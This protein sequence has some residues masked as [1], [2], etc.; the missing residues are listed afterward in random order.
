MKKIKV[1]LESLIFNIMLPESQT[2]LDELNEEI[3]NKNES[4]DI[5]EAKK[6]VEFFIEELNQILKLIE[7]N[8]LSNKDA[9]VMYKKLRL[10]L[11][12]HKH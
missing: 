7:E 10:M 3:T 2:F 1:E 8:K 4:K 12:E 6:D 11:D 9:K 5:I